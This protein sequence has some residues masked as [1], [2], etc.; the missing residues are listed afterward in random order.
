MTTLHAGPLR[1]RLGALCALS[2]LLGAADCGRRSGGEPAA[3]DSAAPAT[4]V[5]VRVLAEA[6]FL[7]TVKL[8]GS[9][10][11][12]REVEI[13]AK[14]AGT[15]AAFP[16]T[17]GD[18]L[19]A[20]ELIMR[21]D[22]RPYAAALA[23]AEAGLLATEAAAAQARRELERA[24]EL[25]ARE[26][27]SEAELEGV[28]LAE[29]QAEGARLAAAAALEQARLQ[30]E[31]TELRAPFAGR[32]AA[33]RVDAHE[34]IAPGTPVAALADLSQVL[35]R[36]SVSEQDAV[37]LA[38][39]QPATL[40]IPALGEARLPGRV[41]AVGV[42]AHPLTRSYEVEIVADNPE[43]RLLSGMAAR[44][45][46]E[47]A[48]WPGAILIPGDAVVEQYGQP[49]A[50]VVEGGLARRRALTLGPASGEQVLVETGLAAGDRLIVQGQW[51]V[52][53]GQPVAASD[54]AR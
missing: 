29:R 27:I 37:R 43:R 11:A 31:D 35:V 17:L 40:S 12:L 53:D 24:R 36:C 34:Q 8:S 21:L 6:E 54:A 10:E 45:E 7:L 3:A 39:G 41:R 52:R 13:A 50:F 26:R 5:G 2:L 42:R 15:V 16:A 51:S 22:E 33:K 14:L 28:G 30:L 23:Q 38:S 9:T 48:R 1:R 18:Q 32:L 25:R 20:G 49:V 19:A 47:I 4:P 44:V 46:V